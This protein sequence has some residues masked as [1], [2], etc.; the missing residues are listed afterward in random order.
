MFFT[1]F[2]SATVLPMGSEA[3]LIYNV[4]QGYDLFV[5]FSVAVVGNTLGSY[6]NYYL[7]FKGEEY[8]VHKKILKVHKI[9]QYKKHFDKYG[10]YTLLLSWIPVFGDG[11]TFIAGI[12][13]YSMMKFF[14]YVFIAKFMRYFVLLI[15]YYN[16]EK[17]ILGYLGL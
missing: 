14:I 12:L 5:L 3:V 9:E 15:L 1:A 8:L 13:R 10:G 16:F 2:C 4:M 7:G 17:E 11:F 6:V